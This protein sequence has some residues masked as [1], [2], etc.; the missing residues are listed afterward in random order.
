MRPTLGHPSRTAAVL[1]LSAEG[2]SVK[3]IAEKLGVSVSDISALKCMR[4]TASW[5]VNG[6]KHVRVSAKVIAGLELHAAKRE[7]TVASLIQKLLETIVEA[8][9]VDSV[10]DDREPY[11]VVKVTVPRPAG[12]LPTYR[13]I[14]RGK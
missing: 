5:L 3:E 1:A 14:A 8:Q 13:L 9:L 4:R 12:P 10:L 7:I 6:G 2:L 11:M